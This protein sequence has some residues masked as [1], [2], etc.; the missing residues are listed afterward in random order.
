MESLTQQLAEQQKL[1]TK[2]EA[3]RSVYIPKTKSIKAEKDKWLNKNI[4]ITK[5][6]DMAFTTIDEQK[7]QIETLV[8]SGE[9]WAHHCRWLEDEANRLFNVTVDQRLADSS[10]YPTTTRTVDG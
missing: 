7:D 2:Y 8:R 3:Q 1:I 4:E 5:E 6:V 10:A 9:Q